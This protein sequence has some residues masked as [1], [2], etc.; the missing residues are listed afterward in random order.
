MC[1][2]RDISGDAWLINW[3]TYVHSLCKFQTLTLMS[4]SENLFS[5]VGTG[6]FHEESPQCDQWLYATSGYV[7]P[8]S[9][10]F[11]LGWSGGTW[12][13]YYH[14]PNTGRVDGRCP[15]MF[16]LTQSYPWDTCFV[17][18]TLRKIAVSNLGQLLFRLSFTWSRY[19][20]AYRYL[21]IMTIDFVAN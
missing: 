2:Y 17:C 7:W 18:S 16:V 12:P 6:Y 19:R 5:A 11:M 13:A 3:S 1:G 8:I 20:N 4:S 15:I 14:W 10:R 21:W 9:E